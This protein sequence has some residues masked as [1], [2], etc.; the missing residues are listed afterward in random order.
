MTGKETAKTTADT[1]IDSPI[2]VNFLAG[3]GA[4]KSTTAA[5]V[6]TLLKLHR[7]IQCELVT[8][9]AKELVWEECQHT[10]MNQHYVTSKQQHRIWR[11]YQKVDITITDSP[12]LLGCIYGRDL[13]SKKFRA[14][15][16]EEFNRYN[17]MNFFIERGKRYVENGRNQSKDEALKIDDEIKDCLSK[18]NIPYHSIE[19]NLNGINTALNLIFDNIGRT[20]KYKIDKV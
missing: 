11:V 14:H 7:G 18:H 3:P 6:F 19:G 10:L 16:L 17:N 15:V 1:N 8:E 20:V 4:G 5:A 12:T 9:F 13:T 2:V